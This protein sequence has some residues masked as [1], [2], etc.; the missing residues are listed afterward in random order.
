MQV[1]SLPCLTRIHCL[2]IATQLCIYCEG[3]ELHRVTCATEIKLGASGPVIQYTKPLNI[4][5]I[6]TTKI[7]SVRIYVIIKS[8]FY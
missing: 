2:S 3:L 8:L 1:Y 4:E 5:G 6:Y 7:A